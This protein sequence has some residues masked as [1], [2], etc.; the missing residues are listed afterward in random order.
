[1]NDT[2]LIMINRLVQNVDMFLPNQEIS[3]LI[4]H[5]QNGRETQN[6]IIKDHFDYTHVILF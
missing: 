6:K 5:V 4:I 1:M 3:G 2:Y